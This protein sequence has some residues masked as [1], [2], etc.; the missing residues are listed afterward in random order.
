MSQGEVKMKDFFISYTKADKDWA[1]WIAW[2]L[3]EANYSVVI[4]AWDFLPGSDFVQDM[5][6]ALQETNRT[7]LVLSDAFLQSA[8]T[9]AEW[10]A[11]FTKDPAGKQRLLIPVR[12]RECQPDGLLT[13]KVYVDLVGLS[14][15]DAKI[16]LLGAFSE[17][18]RPTQA[19][20]FPGARVT[21]EPVPF[22]G[23]ATRASHTDAILAQIEREAEGGRAPD[24][25]AQRA[26][27]SPID[28]LNL[29]RQLNDI[30]MELFNMIVYAV[31]P[32][33]GI[34]PPV[35]ASQGQRS[36]SLLSWAEGPAGCGTGQIQEMLAEVLKMSR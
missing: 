27:L 36:S 11:A 19:P 29:I 4:Q 28:R 33:A 18:A 25:P 5:H 34:V 30:P 8:Y 20:H 16:A 6:K 32:P 22:P 31:N 1:T 14:E 7:I 26:R 17:R 10:S 35:P 24:S 15:Q 2:T 21:S 13:S 23:D 9:A 12:V 3:E